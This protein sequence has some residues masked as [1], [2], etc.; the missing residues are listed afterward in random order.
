MDKRP[1]IICL[2]LAVLHTHAS[3]Q[4]TDPRTYQNTPV[5]IN[6]LELAYAYVRSNTSIDA[7]FVI[8]GAK[9][10]LNQGLVD[11]TR[12]FAFLHR[13]AWVE[14]SLPIANLSGSI[15]GTNITG[16]TTGT[17]DSC[18]SAAILLKGGPALSPAQFANAV[19]TTSIGLSLSTTAPTGQYDPNKLLN[20][21][22]D[23]WSFKPE[24]AISKPFGP[25]QRW[26]FDTYANTYLYTD[27]T[28]YRGAEVLRQ[29][30]LLGLEGHIS[31]TL[32]DTIWASLDTRYSFRGN[33]TV[34]GVN[35]DN[36]QRNFILGTELVVS[37]NS[38]NSFTFEFAKAAVHKN[39]PSLTGFTVKYDYIWGKDRR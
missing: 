30:A 26:V 29:R 18:Y 25:E 20:L 38:R 5:G 17:G 11:Y 15:T 33:T 22:S 24:F 13:M 4:F 23:R 3:A 37:P 35:Q 9:F 36:P 10:N 31:Y 19:N 1:L 7:S 34:S 6:Q 32:N 8:S 12:Y 14:G 16:S 28:S 21:G 39:G 27:N 2:A